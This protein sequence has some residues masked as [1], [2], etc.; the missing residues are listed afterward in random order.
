MWLVELVIAVPWGLEPASHLL[1]KLVS[2]G[3]HDLVIQR[4][5]ESVMRDS[6]ISRSPDMRRAYGSAVSSGG[7][8]HPPLENGDAS[9]RHMPIQ[10]RGTA[11]D[12]PGDFGGRH[13]AGCQHCPDHQPAR[14]VSLDRVVVVP[15][16]TVIWPT[17]P[18]DDHWHRLDRWCG[19]LPIPLRIIT[20]PQR[21]DMQI[22]RGCQGIFGIPALF[23]TA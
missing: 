7:G 11:P 17:R 2:R 14:V 4:F 18:S 1:L 13:Y 6:L 19:D 16:H 22:S 21:L 15:S 10:R 20:D 8:W 5:L 3:V 23:E 12:L 9:T